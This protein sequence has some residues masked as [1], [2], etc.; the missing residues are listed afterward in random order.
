VTK[1]IGGA[2]SR[3]PLNQQ[4]THRLSYNVALAPSFQK[5]AANMHCWAL[6]SPLVSFRGPGTGAISGTAGRLIVGESAHCREC[7]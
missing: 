7:V 1:L 3:R 5:S 2:I 4:A 6:R